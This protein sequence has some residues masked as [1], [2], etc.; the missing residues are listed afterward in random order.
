MKPISFDLKAKLGTSNFH[1]KAEVKSP[2][3]AI[4]GASGSGKTTL[5]TLLVGLLKP[6]DGWFW[7]GNCCLYDKAKGID[8]RSDK[9]GI[10]YVFQN[11]RLFPHL[12]VKENIF[13]PSK[14][15]G[16]KV[17]SN[18]EEIIKVLGL[19]DLLDRKPSEISGGQAQRTALA[20]AIASAER[21]LILDEPLSNLDKNLRRESLSYLAKLP[22]LLN[23]PLFYITHQLDEALNLAETGL[24]IE[25][26]RIVRQGPCKEIFH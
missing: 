3:T 6:T 2:I 16:R 10:G 13:F 8:V 23:V 19:T 5:A 21:L 7:I 25:D 20:R 12:T 22:S 4:M 26:G 14:W 17:P 11:Y 1:F 9:R 18:M 24:Y 15:G